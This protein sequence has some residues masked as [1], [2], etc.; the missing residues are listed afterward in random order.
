MIICGAG[1]AGLLA[2]NMLQHYKPILFEKQKTVPNNHSAV[3][4]FRHKIFSDV[5]G[6]PFKQVRLIKH[7]VPWRNPVADA[8]AYSEKN[9]GVARTDRSIAN[10]ADDGTRYIAPPNLIEQ[11]SSRVTVR[12]GMEVNL[13][14]G[15]IG[16]SEPSMHINKDEP[17]ISTMPMPVLMEAL[18]WPKRDKVQFSFAKGIHIHARITN[19]DAYVGLQFPSPMMPW[20]RASVTG[21]GLIIEGTIVLDNA[22]EANLALR[23]VASQLGIEQTR[24]VDVTVHRQ[25]Y[26]KINPIDDGLRKEFIYWAS[27]TRN[28]YSLGRFATWRPKLLLDDLVQDVH[29]ISSWVGTPDHYNMRRAS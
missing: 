9:T 19:C 16:G 13:A 7:V 15:R 25:A 21:D 5:V 2:A 3:L 12:L 17:V 10:E 24:I 6:I 11:L 14:N 28:V 8:L 23:T 1:L 20:S 29:R 26:A 4:R 18:Q 22:E 27:T